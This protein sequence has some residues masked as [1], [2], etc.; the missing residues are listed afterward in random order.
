M[1][2]LSVFFIFF[3]SYSF[4]QTFSDD[5]AQLFYNNCTTC[6]NPNGIGPFSI[7][8]YEDVTVN[9]G[10][11]YDAIAQDQMPPWPPQESYVSFAHSRTLTE[12]EK[13]TMLD[14]LTN[15]MPE[16]NPANTP[17]PPVFNSGSLLGAG[18]L[19]IQMPSYMSKASSGQDDYV[20]F[21]M[22]T[23]LLANR[24][25]K[26]C[27]LYTSPSPRDVEESRMPSSA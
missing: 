4:S 9:A 18:D 10:M 14:W 1:K 6:H 15:G 8:T 25:I 12:N 5:V 26:A 20:C 2:S 7:M 21:S 11:I 13:T 22:P 3:I 24:S 19:E 16:G 27:L 23:G 17:A